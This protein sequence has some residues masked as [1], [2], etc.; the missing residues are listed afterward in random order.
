MVTL[1]CGFRAFRGEPVLAVRFLLGFFWWRDQGIKLCIPERIRYD[2]RTAILEA[3]GL[4]KVERW[5]SAI[6]SLSAMCSKMIFPTQKDH[7]ETLYLKWH[8]GLVKNVCD[9]NHRNE[10]IHLKT[11]KLNSITVTFHNFLFP[12]GIVYINLYFHFSSVEHVYWSSK[13]FNLKILWKFSFINFRLH[14]YCFA[15]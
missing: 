11:K 3:E 6:T 13:T 4:K 2:T 15:I 10:N 1:N 7:L 8:L 9:W 5:A 14:T 12:I